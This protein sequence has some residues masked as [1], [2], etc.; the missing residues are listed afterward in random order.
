MGGNWDC[1]EDEALPASPQEDEKENE[2]LKEDDKEIDTKLSELKK[3]LFQ[4]TS[5]SYLLFL[6]Y[7]IK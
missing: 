5:K 2:E 4:S 1:S 3:E 6:I 7:T